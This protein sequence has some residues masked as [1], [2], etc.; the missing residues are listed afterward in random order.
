MIPGQWCQTWDHLLLKQIPKEGSKP[1]RNSLNHLCLR[2][3]S[4]SVVSTD[5]GPH[6]WRRHAELSITWLPFHLVSKYSPP[7]AHTPSLPSNG[8]PT[9]GHC[10]PLPF[11]FFQACPSQPRGWARTSRQVDLSNWAARCPFCHGHTS[12]RTFTMLLYWFAYLSSQ[13]DWE[14]E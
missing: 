14:I 13:V 7:S 11:T 10:T 5:C 4:V 1:P 9:E 12:I 6:S 3:F 2:S 8:L